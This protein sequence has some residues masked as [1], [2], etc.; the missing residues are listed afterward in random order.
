MGI[1][2]QRD[3]SFILP[4]RSGKGSLGELMRMGTWWGIECWVIIGFRVV[5]C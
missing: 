2:L 4:T 5:V 1:R 3:S